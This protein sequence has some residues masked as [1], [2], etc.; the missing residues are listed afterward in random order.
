MPEVHN[1]AVLHDV[2]FSFQA[3]LGASAG[4]AKLPA[5][6]KSSYFVTSARMKPR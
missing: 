1:L 6:I 3:Q 2:F 5:A 4:S